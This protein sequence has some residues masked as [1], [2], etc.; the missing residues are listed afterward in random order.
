MSIR[1]PWVLL[2]VLALLFSHVLSQQPT[3]RLANGTAGNWVNGV[4]FVRAH[5]DTMYALC[6]FNFLRS[7]DRGE[8]WDSISWARAHYGGIGIDPTNSQVI[9]ISIDGMR[10]ES[11]DTYRSMDGGRTW[12]SNP[13][14]IGF[15]YAVKVIEFDPVKA[16]TVYIGVGPNRVYR[17]SNRGQTWDTLGRPANGHY[18]SSLSI[19]GTNNRIL[20]AGS[21][22]GVARSSDRGMTWTSLN[23]GIQPPDGVFV[24]VDP[25]DA[26]IVY[27]GVWSLGTSPGGM[28]KT[29]DGGMI[30]NEINNGISSQDWQVQAIAINLRTLKKSWLE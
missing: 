16:G 26:N 28:Y 29:T 20:Y 1:K 3:W 6:R 4:D 8:N 21:F 17:S 22:G 24:A 9:Y 11:N 12:G 2:S 13:L 15:G 10:L 25:R 19:A 14:F 30:W 5:P 18:L 7:T 27:A 23:L